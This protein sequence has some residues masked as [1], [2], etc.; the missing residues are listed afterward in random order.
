MNPAAYTLP[1][2]TAA[3]HYTL[4]I[5]EADGTAR[6][7]QPRK[8]NL[9][10][11]QGLDRLANGDW[12][13]CVHRVV[14]GS[15]TTPTKRDSGAVTFTRA[16]AT[17]TASAGF[18]A[19]DDVGRLLKF[20]TGEEM[21]ITG[22]T[23]STVVTVGTS[24]TLAASEGTV[25]YVNQTA[26]TAEIDGAFTTGTGSA[27]SAGT[28]TLGFT[29]TF[30]VVGATTAIR[31]IGWINNAGPHILF[32]RDL[33]AGAGVTLLAG[34]QLRVTIEFSIQIGPL[35]AQPYT[36]VVTGWT[37]DGEQMLVGYGQHHPAKYTHA[38]A[39]TD[40]SAIGA[41]IAAD[42]V[43]VQALGGY[44]GN[45]TMGA[46]AYTP[47]SFTI[48]RQAYFPPASFASSAIRSI[49]FGQQ[50]RSAGYFRIR[51]DN[52]EAKS[53][54]QSLTFALIFTWGRVLTN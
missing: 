11:D 22:Y 37:S 10:L 30:G 24:G 38:L 35:T 28:W 7:A 5:I 42:Y 21:Y 39:S 43:D 23:S 18:F 52:P 44:L 32:G 29:A 48:V 6:L 14:C 19:S 41:N 33:L 46:L 54:T 8:K 12:Q 49:Y 45:G 53:G 31:E 9:I 2:Q 50:F 17:V 13:S 1:T 36:N 34:Q 26:L 3:V 27:Y 40:S 47:G 4:H 51:L 16:A 15:G 20:D 25:W